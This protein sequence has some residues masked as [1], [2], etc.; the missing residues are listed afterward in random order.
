MKKITALIVFIVF[1][2]AVFT[3]CGGRQSSQELN[4]SSLN[5]PCDFAEATYVIYEELFGHMEELMG[6]LESVGMREPTAAEEDQ[7][8]AIMDKIEAMEMQFEEMEERARIL[9]ITDEEIEQ[10]PEFEK[11]SELMHKLAAFDWISMD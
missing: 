3:G 7:A 1:G 11:V 2:M 8:E 9:G 5:E 4:I 10:C 6:L